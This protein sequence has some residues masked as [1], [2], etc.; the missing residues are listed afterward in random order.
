MGQGEILLTPLQIA[1]FTVAI[2]N[3]GWYY[4]PHIVKSIDGKNNPDPRFKVKH[5]TLVQNTKY[6][7]LVMKGM[8]AVMLRGTG[9]GLKSKDFTQL[10]KTGTAQVPQGK[11]NSI[12]RSS[13]LQTNQK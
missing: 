2:A 13:L 6:Y 4:T 7:E 11:D 5:K 9:A 8:E 12:L 10:A 3:K 1:N